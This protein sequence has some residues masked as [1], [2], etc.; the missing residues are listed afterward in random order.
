MYGHTWGGLIKLSPYHGCDFTHKRS[1]S[2][3][4][5]TLSQHSVSSIHRTPKWR[6]VS[7]MNV[8]PPDKPR[9]MHRCCSD[10]W[11]TLTVR[12][13]TISVWSLLCLAYMSF[14]CS[15]KHYVVKKHWF[16]RESKTAQTLTC[17]HAVSC[18]QLVGFDIHWPR[19]TFLRSNGRHLGVYTC[20]WLQNS[21][22]VIYLFAFCPCSSILFLIFVFLFFIYIF[23]RPN[24]R[25]GGCF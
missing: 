20:L 5:Q 25:G 18:M 1:V 8:P 19:L 4:S 13:A 24:P 3:G 14:S 23:I 15:P 9:W 11:Q 10:T 12:I 17:V 21:P 6:A 22:Y 16:L 7:K 2:S